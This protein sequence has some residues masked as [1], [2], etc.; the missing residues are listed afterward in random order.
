MAD[1]SRPLTTE[2]DLEAGTPT[3]RHRDRR[4]AA[5]RGFQQYARDIR[6]WSGRQS[7]QWS[8]RGLWYQSHERK[9]REREEEGPTPFLEDRL[10]RLENEAIWWRNWYTDMK[11]LL[12]A[13]YELRHAISEWGRTR[14]RW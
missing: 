3:R 1:A 12:G 8:R 14:G 4:R 7:R 5:E 10:L 13:L 6:T 11:E 2:V 9:R